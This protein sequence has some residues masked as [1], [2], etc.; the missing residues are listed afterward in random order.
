MA[1][2]SQHHELGPS[3]L[4]YV[5]ICPGYRSSNETNVF[6][7]EGTM[8]HTAAETGDLSGLNEE[9][10]EAVVLCL[11]YL[12]PYESIADKILKELK[13]PIRYAGKKGI[14][15]SVDRTIIKGTH[16][17]V[18]DFK[19]GRSEIDGADI[20]IQG[21]AYLLG[22]MD[23]YPQ[24]QTATVHF[25][26]P[27]RDEIHTHDYTR[28]DMDTIRLRIQVIVEKAQSETPD[29][30]PNTEGCR[31]CKHRLSCTALSDKLLPV[32]KKYA[33]TVEDFELE[34]M[35][36]YDPA[37]IEDNAVLAKMLNVGNVIDA[38][39][40]AARAEAIR[41]AEEEGE[42]IPGYDLRWRNP[43]AKFDSAQDVFDSLSDLFD[44]EEFMR[45]CNISLSKLAKLYAEKLPRGAKK[46]ARGQL[47][48]LLE[49]AKL[50]PP[51]E[52]RDRTAYL[53][54]LPK[55]QDPF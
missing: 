1:S 23:K 29:L 5:E 54:K 49:E 24:L 34:L 10:T 33:P 3:T 45:A 17:E 48:L 51:E 12:E 37:L 13:V 7:E 8:L 41:R 22:V 40:K 6:A 19:F 27:R 20:N 44:P 42:E 39:S 28:A 18:A 21:Q 2:P 46:G 31:F 25:I 15:G 53:K 52:A 26:I 4:K 30:R 11:K 38:W 35:D 14:F 47:E 16:V 43:T 36:N 9:Q 55:N 32:A 50:L